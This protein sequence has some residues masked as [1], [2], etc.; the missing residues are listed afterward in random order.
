M[1]PESDNQPAK[2]EARFISF[3]QHELNED[4]KVELLAL[5]NSSPEV[6]AEFHATKALWSDMEAFSAPDVSEEMKENFHEMLEN[7][8]KSK[9]NNFFQ[10]LLSQLKSVFTYNPAFR[11]AYALAIL[12]TGGLIGFMLAKSG[13]H[14]VASNSEVKRLGT[15]I[16]EMKQMMMISMLDNPMASERIKAVSYTQELHEVDE[17]II[18]ALLTTLNYDENVNVRLV[19]LNA[20]VELADSPKVREGLVLS[21]MKQDSPLVQVALADVMVQLQEKRSV[22]QMKKLLKKEGLNNMVKEKLEETIINLI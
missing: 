11:L 1:N 18:E 14:N 21:L 2:L 16:Q 5:I 3:L 20:L 15:E 6:E 19:T 17:Q 12:A 9:T 22:Q 4:E 8:S 13:T 7:F 10:S